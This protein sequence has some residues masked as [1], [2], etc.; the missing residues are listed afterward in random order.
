MDLISVV[1]IGL[2]AAVLSVILKQYKPEYSIIVSILA[3]VIILLGILGAVTPVIAEIKNMM[4][5]VQIPY[6]YIT[7]LIK[8]VGICYI[9]QL[10]ADI[11]K[12][13]GQTA[14]SSKVELAGKIAICLLTLPLYR[15]LLSLTQ[16]IIGKVT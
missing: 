2:I 10:V 1:A 14:I 9:T 7:V 12:D 16:T 15:D 3:V 13:A 5:N 6:K 8:S 4:N 11:C